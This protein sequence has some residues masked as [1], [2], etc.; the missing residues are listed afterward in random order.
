ML[1]PSKTTFLLIAL[2]AM[3]STSAKTCLDCICDVASGCKNAPCNPK[4]GTCGYFQITLP[5]YEDCGTPGRNGNEPVENAWK[6]CA[7]D[8]ACSEKCVNAFVA[9]YS[10]NCPNKGACE[11]MARL[12]DG[13]PTGCSKPA[14]NDYWNKVKNCCKCT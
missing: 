3:S 10:K 8:K 9:K 4:T 12:H 7:A 2:L 13:G 14:T 5:Y 6:R 1:I 11:K